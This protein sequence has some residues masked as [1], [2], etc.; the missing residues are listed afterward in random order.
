MNPAARAI[1]EKEKQDRAELRALRKEVKALRDS[2]SSKNVTT[3]MPGNISAAP[4]PSTA[5]GGDLQTRYERLKEVFHKRMQRFREA[6]YLL[7]GFK[8]DMENTIDYA[9]SLRSV[10]KIFSCFSG[11]RMVVW[12]CVKRNP[13]EETLP[14]VWGCTYIKWIRFPHF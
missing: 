6:V 12:I 9:R 10:N 4:T 5:G 11:K 13:F 3:P 8:V 2:W 1:K 14:I 7:T